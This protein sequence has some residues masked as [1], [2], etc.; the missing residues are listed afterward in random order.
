VAARIGG[1]C[2]RAAA[3]LAAVLLLALPVRA[4]SD[5]QAASA[6][7]GGSWDFDLA[8]YSWVADVTGD[9]A[10]DGVA[11]SVEPQLWNDIIRNVDISLF[12]GAEARY[13]NRWIFNVDLNLIRLSDEETRGPMP[14]GFGPATF[15]TALAPVD[16]TIQVDT[17]LGPVQIPVRVDPGTLRVDVPRVDTQIGPIDVDW[18]LTQITSRALVGYRAV[19]TLLSALCG[20]DEDGGDGDPRR[21]RLDLLAGV[22]Y[23]RIRTEVDIESPPIEV[24]PFR[25]RSSISGGR[26]TVGGQVLPPRTIALPRVDLGDVEFPG[27]SFGGTDIEV[28]E[29]EWWIDPVVGARVVTDV[30]ERVSVVLLANVGGFGIGSASKFSWEAMLAARYRLGESWSL[31]AGYRALGYEHESSGQVLDLIQHGPVL[32]AIYSF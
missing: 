8:L 32:G 14:L 24:P 27:L 9:V 3:S 29:T 31:A 22:R 10:A 16:R 19:D 4:G 23:Y 2:L 20:G 6:D 12:G 1:A 26:V 15:T 5:A 7:T 17:R 30:S 25:V 13:E 11:T 28:D 18:R 21:L